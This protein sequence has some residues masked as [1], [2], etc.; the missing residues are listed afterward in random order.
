MKLKPIKWRRK[1]LSDKSG[2]WEEASTGIFMLSAGEACWD[3]STVH[4]NGWIRAGKCR[5][6]SDG[7]RKAEAWLQKQI[8]KIVED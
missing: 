5:S 7:K 1:W 8:T 3:V 2:S 4:P 6:I